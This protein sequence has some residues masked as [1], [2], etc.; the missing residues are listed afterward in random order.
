MTASRNYEFG[1][2]MNI[3]FLDGVPPTQTLILKRAPTKKFAPN[4]YTGIGGGV[5]EGE[6]L[7]AAT[8]R[9]LF[10]ETGLKRNDLIQ[11]GI[12]NVN[13]KK[14]IHYFS[15]ILET[16]QEITSDDGALQWVGLA[17]LFKRKIIPSTELMLR[18]WQRRDFALDRPFTMYI[19]ADHNAEGM[20][21]NITIEKIKEGLHA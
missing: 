9:E 10:E 8:R 14:M 16:T 20:A 13:R 6:S 21:I 18:E 2:Y 5:E 19:H 15:G 7:E 17:E 4:F 11:F 12:L 1:Q 3:H